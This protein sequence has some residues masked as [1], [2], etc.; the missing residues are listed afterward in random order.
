M[1]WPQGL[2]DNRRQDAGG[3][4]DDDPSGCAGRHARPVKVSQMMTGGSGGTAR[5]RLAAR[6]ERTRVASRSQ[7]SRPG[8]RLPSENRKC[9]PCAQPDH[10]RRVQRRGRG[11]GTV[12]RRRADD[13]QRAV[14]SLPQR[15]EQ[16]VPDSLASQRRQQGSRRPTETTPWDN[17]VATPRRPGSAITPPAQAAVLT[18]SFT[19]STHLDEKASASPLARQPGFCL[20]T[21]LP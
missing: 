7:P 19:T 2:D 3:D 4:P 15:S 12:P 16:R 8:S 10:R 5:Q 20:V 13:D 11:V 18:P 17:R 1:R 6:G 14:G 21:A 9:R